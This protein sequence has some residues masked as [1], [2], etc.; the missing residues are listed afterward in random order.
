M[1]SPAD[2]AKMW[3]RHLQFAAAVLGVIGVCYWLA[4]PRER[5]TGVKVELP[6]IS[7]GGVVYSPKASLQLAGQ[8]ADAS[9]VMTNS[10]KRGFIFSP[11][12]G[13]FIR[14][15]TSEGWETNDHGQMGKRYSSVISAH[16]HIILRSGEARTGYVHIPLKARRWQVGYEVRF[17]SG[18]SNLQSMLGSKLS[19]PVI[20]VLG[21]SISDGE[22][23]A[24]VWGPIFEFTEAEKARIE[25]LSGVK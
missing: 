18:R 14:Y 25:R 5:E 3:K 8:C 20:S 23:G 22:E 21:D 6:R 10:G 2:G 15:E 12:S 7:V 11:G 17:A 9:F 24:I 13:D 16:D 4:M 1:N 19:K